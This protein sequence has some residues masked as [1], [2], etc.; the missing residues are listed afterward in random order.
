MLDHQLY[1]DLLKNFRHPLDVAVTGH[2]KR[3]I[4]EIECMID[5]DML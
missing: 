4:A 1:S 2:D 5:D 3:K